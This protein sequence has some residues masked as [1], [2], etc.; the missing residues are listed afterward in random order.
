MSNLL[1]VKLKQ[2]RRTLKI[3]G[4]PLALIGSHYLIK[5][6][7]NDLA[8]KYTDFLIQKSFINNIDNIVNIIFT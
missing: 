8:K 4:V 7:Y 2:S 1:E 3:V 5:H 6:Y